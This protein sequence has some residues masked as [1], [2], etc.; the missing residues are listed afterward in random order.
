ML[1]QTRRIQEVLLIGNVYV[2]VA[3][4]DGNRVRLGILAPRDVPVRRDDIHDATPS[5]GGGGLLILSRRRGERI[6]IGENI[7]LTVTNIAKLRV[8]LG[9]EAPQ[10]VA[11][12]RLPAL[13]D[14][15]PEAG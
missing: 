10:D 4:I 6:F 9:V 14:S 3:R 7:I 2:L 13:P 5:F 8:K 1:L 15:F 11:V 12:S